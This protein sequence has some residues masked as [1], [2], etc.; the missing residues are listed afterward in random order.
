MKRRAFITLIGGAAAAWP[1]AARAQQGGRQ[2]QITVWMGRAN[3]TEGLR[4]A[5]ALREGLRALGWSNGRNVRIDYRWVTG[6]IDRMNL[7]K[8]VVEQNPDVMVVE[9]TPAVAALSRATSTIPIVFINVSDPI[10]SGFIASLAH[11][12]GAITGFMSNEPTLG[13]KWPELLKEIAPAVERVGFLFNPDTA[14]YAEPFLRQA[15]RSR[16]F[17]IQNDLEFRGLLHRQIGRLCPLDYPVYV[18]CRT[19]VEQWE[20]G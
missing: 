5:A 18:R 20:V 4:L 6:D 7:A 1:L 9:T 15:E 13:A 10:G 2:Q 16:C 8:E 12:G 11:P 14:T 17:H 19:L 3:D